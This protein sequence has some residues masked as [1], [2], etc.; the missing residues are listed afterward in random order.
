MWHADQMSL[1]LSS[2][3]PLEG[4][5]RVSPDQMPFG[6]ETRFDPAFVA[7]LAL[8]EKQVQQNYRPVIAIHK[9][10]ARRP[11][12][13]FRSLMLSELVDAPLAESY[14]Q[15]NDVTGLIADPFM[16]GGTTIF[17][18]LRLG[19]GVVGCDINPM[20]YWLVRQAVEP[21]DLDAFRRTADAVVEKVEAS[22]GELYTT[23][24]LSCGADAPVKYFLWSK[25]CPCP[26]CGARVDLHPGYLV[27][28]AVRHPREVYHCPTCETLCEIERGSKRRCLTC[29]RLLEH[30]NT[31][32]GK[33]ECL[34]CGATFVFAPQLAS[35]P[36][37]HLFGIEYQCPTCYPSTPGRQ[38]KT[39]DARDHERVGRA[40]ALF[41]D[42]AGSLSIPEDAIPSGDETTRLHR[43][44]Y[45]LYREMFNGR[46]LLGLGLLLKEIAAVQDRRIRHAL[47]TVFS[48]FLRY[49]NLLGRYDTYALKCQDIFSV[50]GFPVG[51]IVCED[52]LLGIPGVGSGSFVHFVE[53]YATAKDYAQRPYEIHMNRSR[54]TLLHM[55][56][57]RIEAPLTSCEPSS[58]ER[59]AWLTCEPS[60]DLG[61][62]PESLD[63]VFTDPPYFD[64]VQYAELMDFCFVW[65]R[66]LLSRDVT[67]F[68]R[69]TTRTQRELTGNDTLGRDLADFTAGLS[70]VFVQ[71][72]SAL[73][74][75]RPLS[76]TYHHNDP[77]AYAPLVVALL[78]AGL[79]CT[80]VL[81]APAE[82]TASLHIAGTKSSVLD[83]IF[84]CRHRVWTQR[85]HQLDHLWALS[86]ED[87][88]AADV[89]RMAGAGYHCTEGDRLCLRAGHLAGD[90]VR[91]LGGKWCPDASLDD[92]LQGVCDYLT[93]VSHGVAYLG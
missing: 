19:L 47:A 79:T 40:D 11:G 81:P 54:K 60:Q 70:D 84:V 8:R 69:S 68:E 27:A 26:E 2:P 89:T 24:C 39:P 25:C 88:V 12:S 32:R 86:V 91:A 33:A 83:S 72:A 13:V 82:M 53:K 35:P 50:H 45:Q 21:L 6:L 92:R 41:A 51:L 7:A 48:D 71:M 3:E 62:A 75:G 85:R 17:E 80:A 64:N 76:F 37:H 16:G 61:L 20:A 87:R 78:D 90:A 73:K 36:D 55:M 9:W 23:V 58:G 74:K 65:L 57:E 44:G 5:E 52:S 59:S 30:G 29:S 43:W 42:T 67:E 4:P 10:F 66:Q 63:G 18:A 46:Q 22:I 31:K 77:L 14:W 49:Q 38:F 34:S 93:S 1:A 56:G 28:E 15:S